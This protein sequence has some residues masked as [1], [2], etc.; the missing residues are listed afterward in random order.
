MSPFTAVV[1]S[2]KPVE[3]NLPGVVVLGR[4]QRFGKNPVVDLH[5][6]RLCALSHVTTPYFFYLDDDDALPDD[7]LDV[8]NECADTGA[9]LAYTDEIVVSEGVESMRVSREY[10][11]ADHAAHPM[12][13]HHLALMKT[14]VARQAATEIPKGTYNE[15]LLHF[16]VA[17]SGAKYVPRVGYIW[18]KGNGLHNSARCHLSQVNS[19][20]WCMRNLP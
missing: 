14:D 20:S 10:D 8:L 17:K 6:A 5:D 19:A 9:A 2:A 18:N 13:V 1:L 15:T 3:I 4:V 11:A 7:Y 12:M 16:Q